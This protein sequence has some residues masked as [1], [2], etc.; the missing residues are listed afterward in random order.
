MKRALLLFAAA[1]LAAGCNDFVPPV[2]CGQ[3]P[4]GGCPLD[5]G[6]TCDDLACEAIYGCYDARWEVE[7]VC[8]HGSGGGGSAAT[9]GG[10]SGGSGG[11]T[12]IQLDHTNEAV[13]C[14]PDLQL[15]DCP[16]AAAEQC[17]ESACLTDCTDFFMCL[18]EGNSKGWKAVAYCDETGSL[19]V[20]PR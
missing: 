5:R 13:A 4:E 3:I 12:P 6:G 2:L 18:K 20:A 7:E 15:P 11:C 14:E 8:D 16:A 9:G 17:S 10:G 1:A 19:I